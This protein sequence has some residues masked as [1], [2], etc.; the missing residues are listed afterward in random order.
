MPRAFH[1]LTGEYPPHCG[2]VG[3]YTRMVAAGLAARGFTVHVWC[4]SEGAATD[5][6]L[7]HRL[8][9]AFGARSRRALDEALRAMPGSVVLEYVPNALGARGANVAFCAWLLRA[10][11]RGADV[12]VM[13]H[14]PYL[15]FAWRRPSRNVLAAAQRL[16][17]ALLLR[18]SPVS[19]ISTATW[20]RYL[21]PWG[22]RVLL[23]APIPAT[24][25]P[26]ARPSEV[27]RWRTTLRSAGGSTQLVAHFGTFGDHMSAELHAVVP[28]V[29]DAAPAATIVLIGRGASGF[30]ASVAGRHPVLATRVATA[31]A[32]SPEEIAAVLR[33]CDLAVQPY[34]DGVTTRRT[35]V[36]GPLA[37]GVPVVTTDGS[38]TEPIWRAS[39]AVSLSRAGDA[40][41]MGSAAAALLGDGAARSALGTRGRR[42]YEERFALRHTLDAILGAGVAA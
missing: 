29:L 9:D 39:G 25:P 28:A 23:E 38:L 10:H 37:N 17:A 2:G 27:E 8:P 12:R 4:P 19:Y 11:R 34:P 42:V 18:A 33:A 13:F 32:L 15:Y 22:A 20:V 5:G 31:E 1:L 35:S 7:L 26:E 36:M 21:R 41:A 40:R 30:A 3:D 24:I 6:V 14:E 16:M